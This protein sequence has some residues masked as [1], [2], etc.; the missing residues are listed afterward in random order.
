MLS[1]KQYFEYFL[2]M[3]ATPSRPSN[4]AIFKNVH[5]TKQYKTF[6][7]CKF[8]PKFLSM[9][10]CRMDHV[11]FRVLGK[12][13]LFCF[14]FV[15]PICLCLFC[16]QEINC[17]SPR[18]PNRVS[19]IFLFPLLLVSIKGGAGGREPGSPGE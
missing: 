3:C 15:C 10:S 6:K 7:S 9:I 4:C 2:R 17:V 18:V 11:I 8:V 1:R 16:D 13:V 19:L 12:F 5:T 14:I